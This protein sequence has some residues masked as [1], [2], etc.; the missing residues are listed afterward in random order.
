MSGAFWIILAGGLG[1]LVGYVAGR[2]RVLRADRRLDR[3]NAEIVL[4]ESIGAPGFD[5]RHA[6]GADVAHMA[7]AEEGRA[8]ETAGNGE[9]IAVAARLCRLAR[10]VSFADAK[11]EEVIEES[12]RRGF[13]RVVV[14]R[15]GRS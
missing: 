5:A 14:K 3:I 12:A 9:R 13:M 4:L 8:F 1:L 15:G 11:R 2:S 7:L 10:L 6:L